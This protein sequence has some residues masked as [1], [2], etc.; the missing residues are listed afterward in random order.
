MREVTQVRH[1]VAAPVD[2]DADAAGVERSRVERRQIRVVVVDDDEHVRAALSEV[3]DAQ[4]DLACVGHALDAAGAVPACREHAADVVVI[5][6]RLPG[7][8]GVAATREVVAH[9]PDV[10]IVALST[11]GDR[12]HRELMR[13]AGAHRYVAKG[14]PATE[15]LAA[16]REVARPA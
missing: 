2:D 1:V 4:P 9:C 6:V 3:L 15:L 16:I 10:G 13:A 14:A 12:R 5:D 11:F 7:G 8:G